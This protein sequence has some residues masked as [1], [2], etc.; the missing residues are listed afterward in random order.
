[1]CVWVPAMTTTTWTTTG[2][3]CGS[4]RLV[5]IFGVILQSDIPY[6]IPATFTRQPLLS[7][8]TPSQRSPILVIE[9]AICTTL[10]HLAATTNF[11]WNWDT[12]WSENRLL[13]A[14]FENTTT[15]GSINRFHCEI[16]I[17][18]YITTHLALLYTH[19]HIQH[20]FATNIIHFLSFATGFHSFF[21]KFS[22]VFKCFQ[23]GLT[24]GTRT[25]WATASPTPVRQFLGSVFTKTPVFDYQH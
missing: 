5:T 25:R 15:P 18:N 23:V 20:S 21:Y 17:N 14:D 7:S 8:R 1:M 2:T 13:P 19:F 10:H 4:A 6:P 11:F 16:K 9:S 3:R 12:A 22:H 24:L